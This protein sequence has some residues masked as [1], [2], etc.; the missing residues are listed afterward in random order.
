[1]RA[2]GKRWVLVADQDAGSRALVSRL[3]GHIGLAATAAS[4]GAEALEAISDD[5]PA[6]VVIDVE[7]ER[8]SAYQLCREL[9]E[10]FGEMLPI[11]FI[12]ETRTSSNDEIAGLLL[13]ADDYF[14]KPLEADRFLARVRRLVARSP[15]AADRSPLTPREREVLGLLV[16]GRRPSEIADLLCITRKT[17]S[18]HIDHIMAK[19][20]AHTQAQ[21]IAFAVRDNIAFGSR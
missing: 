8:P 20:G 5:M 14:G 19:L 21:A 12:S 15:A 9:R 18:T 10:Q 17:A 4:S 13:G 16:E 7:L 3:V 2:Q 6:L 1:M 11:V